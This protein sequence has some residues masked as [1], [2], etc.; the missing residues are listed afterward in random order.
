MAEEDVDIYGD[1][2]FSL[3]IDLFFFYFF[4]GITKAFDIKIGRRLRRD[5]SRCANEKEI[6]V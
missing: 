6:K 2:D 4:L 1:Y 5:C 3:V